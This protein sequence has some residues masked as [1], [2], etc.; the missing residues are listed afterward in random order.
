[1]SNF[2]PSPSIDL[3]E[4]VLN[5]CITQSEPKRIGIDGEDQP[6]GPN[7]TKEQPVKYDFVYLVDSKGQPPPKHHDYCTDEPRNTQQTS[8]IDGEDF[9]D[10]QPDHYN[11]P[12]KHIDEQQI[13]ADGEDDVD[14]PTVT[15][16]TQNQHNIEVKDSQGGHHGDHIL[17]WMV[18]YVHRT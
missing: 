2:T 13:V 15:A 1:M 18:S 14:A 16:D 10:D 6:D 4:Y 8:H 11:I 7:V 3:A 9:M 17:D 5:K 12:H